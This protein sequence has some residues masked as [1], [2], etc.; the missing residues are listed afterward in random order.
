MEATEFVRRDNVVSTN[1]DN[2]QKPEREM[3]PEKY[4]TRHTRM[5]NRLGLSL[6]LH[7]YLPYPYSTGFN[8]FTKFVQYK[9]CIEK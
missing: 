5:V 7:R 2:D 8:K 4:A 9:E 3:T 6:P 1:K